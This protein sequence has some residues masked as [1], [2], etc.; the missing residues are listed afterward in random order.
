MSGRRSLA[1][2]KPQKRTA[3][4]PSMLMTLVID[5]TSFCVVGDRRSSGRCPPGPRRGPSG[6]GRW[7]RCMKRLPQLL[8]TMASAA[9]RSRRGRRPALA[10]LNVGSALALQHLLL[11]SIILFCLPRPPRARAAAASLLL[12]SLP[13]AALP[14]HCSVGFTRHLFHHSARHGDTH[15]KGDSH[16]R[17]ASSPPPITGVRRGRRSVAAL[18]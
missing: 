1:S 13:T 17:M 5:S 14:Q 16:A 8:M 2:E 4:A 18:S 10:P 6:Q 15:L 3:P 9:T 12:S 11:Y 7:F